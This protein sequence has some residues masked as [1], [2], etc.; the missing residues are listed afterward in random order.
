[1]TSP[2]VGLAGDGLTRLLQRYHGVTIEDVLQLV[3]YLREPDDAVM[4]TGSLAVG[5]GNQK[6]DLDLMLLGSTT[7]FSAAVP[8]THFVSSLRVDVWKL[9]ERV[10][11]R[12]AASAEAA[13]DTPP[14]RRLVSFQ[15]AQLLQRYACGVVIDGQ[16]SLEQ[17]ALFPVVTRL[18]KKYFT[19]M[20]VR[21]AG[22][23]LLARERGLDLAAA[24]TARRAL[25]SAAEVRLAGLGHP[26]FGPK[27]IHH[28]LRVLDPDGWDA[29]EQHLVLPEVDDAFGLERAALASIELA[30]SF[31]DTDLTVA[32]DATRFYNPGSELKSPGS[33]HLLIDQGESTVIE[34]SDEE[35]AV[36]SAHL[37]T[38]KGT[39]SGPVAGLDPAD[40]ALL[41]DLTFHA[42]LA[43]EMIPRSA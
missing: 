24:V 18:A 17:S 28:R 39:V 16:P 40:R 15:D 33:K 3:E 36:W 32:L 20:V 12:L 19:E 43:L 2:A 7:A 34:L 21:D 1:M 8:L 13:L 9:D 41:H 4:L 10:I 37:G 27:W 42:G 23:A 6:S 31:A 14:V 5:L 25:E 35:A 29:I 22:Y 30:T 11:D 38:D 26:F